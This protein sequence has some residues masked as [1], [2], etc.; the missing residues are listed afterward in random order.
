MPT[1]F[2]CMVR[3]FTIAFSSSFQVLNFAKKG[4]NVEVLF[5]VLFQG[6]IRS[7][8][9]LITSLL[10]VNLLYCSSVSAVVLFDDAALAVPRTLSCV[11]RVSTGGRIVN[12]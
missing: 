5:T 12:L 4:H 2:Q 8:R 10:F 7:Y 1:T 6:I 3:S 9:G 11:G